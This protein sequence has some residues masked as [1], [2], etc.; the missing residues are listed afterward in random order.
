MNIC[1]LNAAFGRQFETTEALF[2]KYWHLTC[3]AEALVDRGMSVTV[4]QRFHAASRYETAG[5]HYR[6]FAGS[7]GSALREIDNDPMNAVHLIGL[8]QVSPLRALVRWAA[9]TSCRVT[10][11][12]HGGDL[13]RQP[14]RRWLQ[15][16]ALRNVSVLLF[17]ADETVAEWRALGLVNAQTKVLVVPEI[18]SPFAGTAKAGAR[19]ELGIKGDPVIAWAA[20]LNTNKDPMTVLRAFEVVQQH[21]RDAEIVL[22]YQSAELMPDIEAFLAQ[23]PQ[24]AARVRLVGELPHARME[25]LFSAAD[26][27]VQA[28]SREIGGNSLIEAMSC[29]A[30]PLVTDIPSFRRLTAPVDA[31]RL[32]VPQDSDD[33]AAKILAFDGADLE[34][35]RQQVRRHFEESLSY[36]AIARAY[37]E[38]LQSL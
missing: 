9:N 28:S 27:F 29:G 25:T 38:A 16:R 1:L 32:F 8:T 11:S 12:F 2:A 37:I 30:I 6:T 14:L 4:L 33:L 31:A 20:R 13:R 18:S 7:V 26:F 21:W 3:L 10:A 35:L 5:V 34:E 15:R 17:P 23:R 36:P 19:A 22:A 24:L